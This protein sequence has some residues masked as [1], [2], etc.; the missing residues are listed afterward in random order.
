MSFNEEC[1]EG[2]GAGGSRT[3]HS[4]RR[5]NPSGGAVEEGDQHSIRYPPALQ[6]DRTV[7]V[8]ILLSP[9]KQLTQPQLMCELIYTYNIAIFIHIAI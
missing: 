4:D 9:S 3:Y 7:Y 5:I 8:L 2:G 6:H 1:R